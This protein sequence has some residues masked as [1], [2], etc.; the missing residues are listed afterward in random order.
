MIGATV[1][2]MRPTTDQ[3]RVVTIVHLVSSCF[4]AGLIWTVHLLHYPLFAF[5]GES[6]YVEFQSEHVARVGPLL[7]LPWLTE[8]LTLLV[9]LWVAFIRG[10]ASLR[11]PMALNA[12]A[13]GVVL[14][15]SGFWSAPAHGELSDG[16]QHSV[17]DRLMTANLV[18]TLAWTICAAMAVWVLW[19]VLNHESQESESQES[20]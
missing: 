13:M 9:L 19:R 14:V 7:F 10:A 3:I 5:V 8:G 6:T 17:H 15:I 4:M 11:V 16:F 20:T 1:Y 12:A 18:R 2:S